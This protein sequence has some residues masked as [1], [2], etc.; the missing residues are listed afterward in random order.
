M[1]ATI[2]SLKAAII[3][4]LSLGML[5]AQADDYTAGFKSDLITFQGDLSKLLQIT[6]SPDTSNP[7]PYATLGAGLAAIS[8]YLKT[9]AADLDQTDRLKTDLAAFDKAVND[10]HSQISP[11]T[12]GT[13][14]N[15]SA[16]S[17]AAWNFTRPRNTL[18][19]I[20]TN[21]LKSSDALTEPSGNLQAHLLGCAYE[22][23]TLGPG[24][25]QTPGV[26]LSGLKPYTTND[27]WGMI[28][29][30]GG[31]RY[32]NPYTISNTTTN[33]KTTGTLTPGNK[34]TDGFLSLEGDLR[35]I[36]R[37]GIYE[38]E[39]LLDNPERHSQNAAQ[40]FYPG[41]VVPDVD[42][43]LGYVFSGTSAPSNYSASTIAGSG[44]YSL[45]T[46]IGVPVIRYK[47]ASFLDT[48]T[49]K[50][51][52]TAPEIVAGAQTDKDFLKIYPN[53]S[54]N[55]GFQLA[56]P[57]QNFYWEGQAG[58]GWIDVPEIAYGSVVSEDS[59]NYPKFQFSGCFSMG[60]RFV[61]RVTSSISVE[62]G[63]NVYF[64]RLGSWNLF[65]AAS[66]DPTKFFSALK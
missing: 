39:Y 33:K 26:R 8:S 1:K 31:A 43:S 34:S 28:F 38:D 23:Q 27:T 59:A 51:Q 29:L 48:N 22:L 9:I 24:L 60:S 14:T 66:I 25:Y 47:P 19:A 40:V 32:E 58:Y 50:M 15:S 64:A 2:R 11:L 5:S 30:W 55:A 46:T 35:Y 18:D 12:I 42:F 49:I 44:D 36:F 10:Y 21:D 13:L 45:N 61:Y 57:S 53:V 20:I 4:F 17:I 3:L 37:T 56:A 52:I 41:A 16:V 65:A 62:M 54:I 63:G 7:P 6:I